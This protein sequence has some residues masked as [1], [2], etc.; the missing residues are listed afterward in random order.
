MEIIASATS[1]AFGADLAAS[2]AS[3][4]GNVWALAF[5]AIGIPLAFYIVKQVMGL[6]PKSR[7]R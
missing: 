1:T 2:V 5:I 4:L 3:T 6:F 7:G